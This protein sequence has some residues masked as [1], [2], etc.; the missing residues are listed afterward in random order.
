MTKNEFNRRINVFFERW[1]GQY[2][3]YDNNFGTQCKDLFSQYN[4]DVVGYGTY[5]KGDA[6]ALY[7]AAPDSVYEKIINTRT[8]VPQHGDVIIWGKT[9]GGYG[10][11][12]IFDSG[13]ANKMRVFGE[14]YPNTTKLDANNKV[15]KNGSPCQF[16]EM[17]YSGVHGYLRPR[18][19]NDA[20]QVSPPV[21]T[22]DP[23]DTRINELISQNSE[24]QR[25]LT[26]ETTIIRPELQKQLENALQSI[27]EANSLIYSLKKENSD[28]K[29]EKEGL[30]TQISLKTEEIKVLNA[31]IINLQ[32]K[33]TNSIML[34]SVIWNFIKK[35]IPK[36][37]K[38]K[39]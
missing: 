22:V 38:G 29:T 28:I 3:N 9:F 34:E 4:N 15:I 35:I 20:E 6:W 5:I 10:H 23:K 16:V 37:V 19:T 11:V 26:E 18:N 31:K 33:P 27:L 12:A 7:G 21:V 8:S 2:N 39:K 13:D 14:N 30:N 1:N 17:G 36:I 25:K 24:L 32:N